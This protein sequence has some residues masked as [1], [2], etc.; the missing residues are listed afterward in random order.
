MGCLGGAPVFDHER[1]PQCGCGARAAQQHPLSRRPPR[2]PPPPPLLC[3][4]P[5]AAPESTNLALAALD[6]AP[7]V[8]IDAGTFKYVLIEAEDHESGTTRRLVR[9]VAGAP[10][11]KDV[12]RPTV[13][14]LMDVGCLVE[15]LGGGR[16][17]HDPAAR[18]V[19]I[20]GYSYLF[21][22]ADHQCTRRLILEDP[23]FEGYAVEI[24]DESY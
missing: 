14:A 2:R 18:R 17:R 13:M 12:A 1:V 7:P 22:P 11:H 15:V 21:G 8:A 10:Y 19:E 24:T 20:F 4:G 5:Q 3:A 16:I 23:A 6:T 9:G